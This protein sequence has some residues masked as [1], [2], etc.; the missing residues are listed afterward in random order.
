MIKPVREYSLFLDDES[1]LEKLKSWGLITDKA[2]S[3]KIFYYKGISADTPVEC[4]V[5]GFVDD[6]EIIIQDVATDEIGS[7]LPAYFKQMQQ[8]NFVCNAE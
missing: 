5:I 3:I 7:I 2:T 6:N 4:N 8:K 1:K